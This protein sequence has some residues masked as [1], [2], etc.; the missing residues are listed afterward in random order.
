MWYRSSLYVRGQ[1]YA[2]IVMY[3]ISYNL[4]LN[5]TLAFIY[6]ARC[7]NIIDS[8]FNTRTD[9]QVNYLNS[10]KRKKWN[11]LWYIGGRR[12]L[13]LALDPL[14]WLDNKTYWI[15]STEKYS[16]IKRPFEKETSYTLPMI[17]S[18]IETINR[19]HRKK[20][21]LKKGTSHTLP[22]ITSLISEAINGTH[23]SFFFLV[24]E[25]IPLT[26]TDRKWPPRRP[27]AGWWRGYRRT[28]TA[29]RRAG[30]TSRATHD[31]RTTLARA[32]H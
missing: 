28:L 4:F 29:P 22:L 11:E 9:L 23:R 26:G 7:W 3:M 1:V 5:V 17:T 31:V 16:F 13:I 12:E 2:F 15:Q 20:V 18:I 8:F 32:G 19:K 21:F 6:L 25:T 10:R 27:L 24:L 14:G 30:L